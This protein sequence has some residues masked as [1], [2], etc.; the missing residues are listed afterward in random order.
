MYYYLAWNSWGYFSKN[1]KAGITLG[2]FVSVS[3]RMTLDPLLGL[4]TLRVA[5]LV[6]VNNV[7]QPTL[8]FPLFILAG[9]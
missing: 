1:K 8:I 9:G 5:S 3:V 7:L 2:C 4:L 6:R